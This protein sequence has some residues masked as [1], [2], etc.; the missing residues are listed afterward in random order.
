MQTNY[1]QFRPDL[2]G[3]FKRIKSCYNW[4][5]TRSKLDCKSL[6]G[7]QKIKKEKQFNC[8]SELNIE[9]NKLRKEMGEY[10]NE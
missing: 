5:G 2:K 8:K 3:I 4:K 10:V 9:F 6:M 7:K 1:T